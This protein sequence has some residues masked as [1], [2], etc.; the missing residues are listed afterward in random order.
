MMYRAED[1][2]VGACEM[3]PSSWLKLHTRLRHEQPLT[4]A[5]DHRSTTTP[6]SIATCLTNEFV[7]LIDHANVSYRPR[8]GSRN[9]ET[10]SHTETLTTTTI[11]T[12]LRLQR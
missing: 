5:I 8:H 12:S 10:R 3:A 2:R 9:E 4:S 1:R 11:I 6:F 7:E